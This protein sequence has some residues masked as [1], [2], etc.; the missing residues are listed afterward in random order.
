[1][2]VG[3]KDIKPARRSA[4]VALDISK[5]F[6]SVDH[7]ILLKKIC[8]SGLDSNYV[9]WMAAYLR[10]RTASCVFN[11]VKSA[12]RI[13]R[14]GN[15]QGSLLSPDIYNYFT[16]DCSTQA[17]IHEVFADDIG[18][19]ESDVSPHVIDDK[20]QTSIDAV[21]AWAKRKKHDFGT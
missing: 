17:D 7:M 8:D 13:I 12:P 14:S 6:D 16:S 15:P 9:R 10:C 20:L 11:G 5:A 3:F 18:E 1:V 19:M 4:L 21:D 2:A